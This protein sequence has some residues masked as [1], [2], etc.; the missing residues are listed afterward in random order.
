MTMTKNTAAQK[1]G[2]IVVSAPSGAGK[3]T[4]C[5]RL[6]QDLPARLALSIS[7]TSRAP[8]GLE[9]HG[10]EYFFHPREEFQQKIKGDHFAEWALVHENYYGTLKA[11]LENFWS[12]QKHVLLDIDVQGAESL[13][14]AYPDR[15]YTVFIAPPSLEELEKRLRG[16]QTETE[17]AIQRRMKNAHA[18]MQRHPEFDLVLVNDVFEET[19]LEL[20]TKV[21]AVMNQLEAGTWPKQ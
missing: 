18:E 8:R 1:F 7:S 5:A 13:R 12:Q 21:E 2:L 20:K 3:S 16:R 11:T 15:C 6:L 19:Y 4:L 10:K 17:E 14:R 9:Q